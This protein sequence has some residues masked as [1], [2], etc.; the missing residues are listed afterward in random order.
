MSHDHHHHHTG[1][2]KVLLIALVL[3][4]ILMSIEVI[5]GILTNSL[6][7][8][9]DATHMLSDFFA[10]GLALLAFKFGERAA[11]KS[12][13]FGYKRIEILA[14]LANGVILIGISAFVIWHA[15]ERFISPPEVAGGGVLITASI[16]IVIN[17]IIAGVFLH[18][19]DVKGNLNIQGAFLHVLG[20]I[21]STIGVLISGLLMIF[22]DWMYA[23]PIISMI[24]SLII[25]F[26]GFR[27]S[28]NAIH[29]LME[30]KPA[31]ISL[32]R[33]EEQLLT[34]PNVLAVHDLHVWSITSD[35]PAFSGHLV[36][37]TETNRDEL[38]RKSTNL[39]QEKFNLSHATIQIE[40]TDW[41][42]KT[43]CH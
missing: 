17:L 24:V 18:G 7:L 28:K 11:S 20:D 9:A 38:L 43:R 2:K 36:V 29:V 25:L 37:D 22:F 3:I 19:G 35:F 21:L 12:K 32:A 34:L 30:G 40:G 6:A 31:S 26:T 4:A 42:C 15:M 14:A 39:L 16:A 8:L 1:N 13:T 27:I 5:G 41:E 23:D 33:I 10:I